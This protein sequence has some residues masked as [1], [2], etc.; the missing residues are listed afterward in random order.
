MRVS[1][2]DVFL[3][4]GKRTPQ[5]KSGFDLKDVSAPFLGLSLLRNLLDLNSISDESVDEVIVGNTGAPPQYA[6]VARV[7][8]LMAVWIRLLVPTLFIEIVLPEWRLFLK[9]SLKLRPSALP[10]HPRRRGGK[11]EPNASNI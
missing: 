8:A 10:S 11:Y 1:N 9:G 6:N 2:Q 3:V 7:I 5:V 4:E